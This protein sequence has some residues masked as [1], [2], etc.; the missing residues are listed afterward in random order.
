MNREGKLCACF[1]HPNAPSRPFHKM[2]TCII[3]KGKY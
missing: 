3:C 2:N 1:A